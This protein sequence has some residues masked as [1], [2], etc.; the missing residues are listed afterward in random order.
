MTLRER[1]DTRRARSHSLGNSLWK[2]LWSCRETTYWMIVTRLN[3][4]GQGISALTN[5]KW[6]NINEG[7]LNGFSCSYITIK[8]GRYLIS[9]TKYRCTFN[10][11]LQLCTQSPISSNF[12]TLTKNTTEEAKLCSPSSYQTNKQIAKSKRSNNTTNSTK[13]QHQVRY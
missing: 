2:M 7:G 1:E 9:E 13:A 5:T 8:K 10:L 11:Y 4:Q 6:C 3:L 12:N